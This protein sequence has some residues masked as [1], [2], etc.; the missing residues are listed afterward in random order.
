MQAELARYDQLIPTVSENLLPVAR[1]STMPSGALPEKESW[2]DVWRA[3]EC[4]IDNIYR[5]VINDRR[6]YK[7]R[8]SRIDIFQI[9]SSICSYILGVVTD[10]GDIRWGRVALTLAAGLFVTIGLVQLRRCLVIL[11]LERSSRQS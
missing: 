11:D 9:M 3:E 7:R 2:E 1:Y 6:S 4:Q 5:H 8:L 10:A